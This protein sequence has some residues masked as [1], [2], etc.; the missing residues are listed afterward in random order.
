MSGPLFRATC[1]ACQP[2]YDFIRALH[3]S[4]MLACSVF[5]HGGLER[6][7]NRAFSSFP[8][9]F[10]SFLRIIDK[11]ISNSIQTL[12]FLFLLTLLHVV[13]TAFA[14]DRLKIVKK[15]LLSGKFLEIFFN[16][17]YIYV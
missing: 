14:S 5:M 3:H 11:R 2:T 13:S 12:D 7:L 16:N 15:N 10:N 4:I 6:A 8:P 17:I 9:H 1:T